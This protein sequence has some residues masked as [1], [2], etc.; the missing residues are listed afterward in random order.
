[1]KSCDRLHNIGVHHGGLQWTFN[2]IWTCL[3]VHVCEGISSNDAWPNKHFLATLEN[4]WEKSQKAGSAAARLILKCV[5]DG[6]L[7]A[8]D[9]FRPW[10]PDRPFDR[11]PRERSHSDEVVVSGLISLLYHGGLNVQRR[12]TLATL[13]EDR[14]L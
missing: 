7:D 2:R 12:A 6:R 8:E 9:T 1:M 5:P 3:D 14:P 4:L 13:S 10:D 11:F